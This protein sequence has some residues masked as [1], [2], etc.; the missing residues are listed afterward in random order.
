MVPHERKLVQRMAGRPFALL[1]ING[2]D[3]R[4]TAADLMAK[5]AMT[6]PSFWNGGKLGGFAE[7]L[8]VRAWPTIYVLDATGTIRYKNVRGESLDEAVDRLVGELEAI[9]K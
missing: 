5:E 9:A 1:G 3:D 4:A 6:W 2:D 7:K 8:A